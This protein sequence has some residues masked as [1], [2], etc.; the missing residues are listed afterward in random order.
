MNI[1]IWTDHNHCDGVNYLRNH[2]ETS[3]FLL[4]NLDEHGPYKTNHQNS[5]NF[6]QI[7]DN[8]TV[9]G[10]FCLANRGNLLIEIDKMPDYGFILKFINENED[11][12]I[13][14]V[15]GEYQVSLKVWNSL[16]ELIPAV[17]E[18]FS[19]KE[20]LY[21]LSLD[22]GEY[23][24]VVGGNIFERDEF[25]SYSDMTSEFYAESGMEDSSTPQQR[26]ER[27]NHY[28]NTKSLWNYK[29]NG[30]IVSMANLNS[31][32][33]DIAQVGG[34]YTPPKHRSKGFSKQCVR[35]LIHDCKSSLGISTIILF[36]GSNN[37][38]AQK[39]YESVGFKRI[40]HYGMHFGSISSTNYIT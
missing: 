23:A 9:C 8:G 38:S 19:S 30:E 24:D 22:S 10:V 26:L 1:E 14:G 36:T 29:C 35:K 11:V 6:Y 7:V 28:L 37:L 34:V 20:I 12:E 27:F 3:M 32:L 13:T 18:N 5:G 21:S 31:M 33:V 17:S 25:E 16:K 15:I 2:K 39:V 40:G 4:G